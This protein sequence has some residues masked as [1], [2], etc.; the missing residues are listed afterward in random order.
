MKK[1]PEYRLGSIPNK[2]KKMEIYRQTTG[3]GDLQNE[4]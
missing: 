1:R 2:T 3:C 4:S